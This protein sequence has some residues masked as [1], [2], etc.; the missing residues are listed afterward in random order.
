[1]A[2]KNDNLNPKIL[3]P[4][5]RDIGV[6]T[7]RTNFTVKPETKIMAK[8]IGNGNMSAGVD[9]AVKAAG[10]VDRFHTLLQ[11]QTTEILKSIDFAVSSLPQM[12]HHILGSDR[13][14]QK[15]LDADLM[16]W[17]MQRELDRRK[18]GELPYSWGEMYLALGI[19]KEFLVQNTRF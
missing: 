4:N 15:V 16:R 7:V 17:T 10:A 14:E 6:G 3:N 18:A 2:H 13:V 12:P 19:P 9:L 8:Q 1:M 5:A 11:T